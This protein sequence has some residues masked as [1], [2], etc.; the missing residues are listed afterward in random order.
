MQRS[1]VQ[2]TYT[3]IEDTPEQNSLPHGNEQNHH[4]QQA[5][6][7]STVHAPSRRHGND[8]EE[9]QAGEKSLS[10]PR[11]REGTRPDRVPPLLRKRVCGTRDGWVVSKTLVS[12]TPFTHRH[13]TSTPAERDEN[14]SND[15][16]PTIHLPKPLLPSLPLT[17]DTHTYKKINKATTRGPGIP[18]LTKTP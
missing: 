11:R 8:V 17:Y 2:C 5:L 12:L 6:P 18:R 3:M 10:H 7:C 13:R 15:R 4:S 16:Y 1:A 14:L 9:M